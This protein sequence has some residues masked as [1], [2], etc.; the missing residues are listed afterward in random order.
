MEN[1]L[2]WVYSYAV[3]RMRSGATVR[4]VKIAVTHQRASVIVRRLEFP[5]PVGRQGQ[6][7]PPRCSGARRQCVGRHTSR[8]SPLVDVRPSAEEP[9][10]R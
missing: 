1:L 9:S 10:S 8:A 5:E 3:Q 2:D 6:S 4:P 7:R